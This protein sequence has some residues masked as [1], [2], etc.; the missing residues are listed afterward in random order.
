MIAIGLAS[1][2]LGV[3]AVR[4][5]VGSPAIRNGLGAILALGFLA[6]V[7]WVLGHPDFQWAVLDY[8]LTLAA[9][10]VAACFLWWRRREASAPSLIG[11]IAVSFAAAGV[12]QLELSPHPR[13]N[14]NDLYHLVQAV[15]LWLF[16]RAGRRLPDAAEGG[17]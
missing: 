10:L 6:Y 11:A 1:C 9:L 12:Q 13:F 5:F 17:P 14:H 3:A 16:Y 2:L 4:A 15:G 8:G 7:W